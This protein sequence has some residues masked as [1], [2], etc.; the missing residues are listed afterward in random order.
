MGDLT[1][2]DFESLFDILV[3]VS[4]EALA[5]PSVAFDD[6]AECVF[7]VGVELG[8]RFG[9]RLGGCVRF[10]FVAG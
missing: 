10:G 2:G 5:E 8:D 9:M 3:G 1:F 7:G 6:A 4:F